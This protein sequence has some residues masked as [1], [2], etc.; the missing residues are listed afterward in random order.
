MTLFIGS[1]MNVEKLFTKKENEI[2][3]TFWLLAIDWRF[4]KEKILWD[5][6]K[7]EGVKQFYLPGLS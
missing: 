7:V 1:S 3:I 4:M 5:K 6:V 2:F